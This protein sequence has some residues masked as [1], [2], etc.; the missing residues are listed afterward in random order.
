MESKRGRIS[1]S[2]N[3]SKRGRNTEG[4]S[5]KSTK[6][7]GTQKYQRGTKILG[8]SQLLQMVHK[9]LYQNS[10]ATTCTSQKGTEMKVGKE[11]EGDIQKTQNSVHNRTCLGYPRH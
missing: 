9:G 11:A 1:G 2:S 7:A 4:E 5:E 6:L 3:Q 10:Y 8:P